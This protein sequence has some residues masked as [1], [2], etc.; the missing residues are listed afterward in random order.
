MP[1]DPKRRT[2]RP[3][4]RPQRH[5]SRAEPDS[6]RLPEPEAVITRARRTSAPPGVRTRP[7][8]RIVRPA[9][10]PAP[11][12]LTQPDLVPVRPRL[13]TLPE[14]G[15]RE[16]E[17]DVSV[18]ALR[19]QLAA[20]QQELAHTKHRL[21]KEQDERVE[22]TDRLSDMLTRV[23]RMETNLRAAEE[24][25]GRAADGEAL[26]REKAA[27]DLEQLAK[28]TA[29]LESER[30]TSQ[31]LRT[32]GEQ[33][34]RELATFRAR[35][36]DVEVG[37]AS[38]LEQTNAREQAAADLSRTKLELEQTRDEHARKTAD[39]AKDADE[40]ISAM[41][42]RLVKATAELDALRTERDAMSRS[43]AESRA[44]AAAAAG[45]LVPM[46]EVL[47]TLKRSLDGLDRSEAQI[48]ALREETHVTRRAIAEQAS[49]LE[50]LL[51]P[52]DEPSPGQASAGVGPRN[53]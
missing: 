16:A 38:L 23:T 39:A 49:A 5:D 24:R 26:A 27:K 44:S 37:T 53:A 18:V 34:T 21:T 52:A 32:A 31:W 10:V 43:L 7:T 19:K 8:T 50:L 9:P 28:V 13:G 47:A 45:R 6:V 25:A 51:M 12:R 41:A 3:S 42:D 20:V 35:D 33:T 29:E 11:E 22:E 48:H 14:A 2:N 40:Q 1:D 17:A 15:M 36:R 46:V 4:K 30:T